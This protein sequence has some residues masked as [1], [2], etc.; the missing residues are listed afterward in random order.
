M[1]M[2]VRLFILSFILLFANTVFAA[3]EAGIKLKLTNPNT[4]T[5]LAGYKVYYG[6]AT[7]NYETHIDF[8]NQ[9][10][11]TVTGLA[12]GAVYYL[13]LTAYD[14]TGN[15]SGYSN[16]VTAEARDITPPGN[17]QVLEIINAT[18]TIIINP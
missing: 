6:I 12:D 13:A 16:E 10:T 3:D 11:Y 8:G 15:E 2:K 5:D 14:L 17:P 7:E 1:K 18:V 9:L 4:E